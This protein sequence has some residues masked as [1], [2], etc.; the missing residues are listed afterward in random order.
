M[1]NVKK[2]V[3]ENSAAYAEF[4]YI[5]G[6]KFMREIESPLACSYFRNAY[7]N[8]MKT[9][10]VDESAPKY[11]N[12]LDGLEEAASNAGRYLDVVEYRKRH[13]AVTKKC[14]GK[15]A[16]ELIFSMRLLALAYKDV[17]NDDE[18]R[19]MR[20]LVFLKCKSLYGEAD[21][22]TIGAWGEYCLSLMVFPSASKML[23][24]QQSGMLRV[25]KQLMSQYEESSERKDEK[26]FYQ[27]SCAVDT[28]KDYLSTENYKEEIRDIDRSLLKFAREVYPPQSDE[29]YSYIKNLAY[30]AED[31]ESTR[32]IEEILDYRKK[33]AESKEDLIEALEEFASFHGIMSREEEA[34]KTEDEIRAMREKDLC[35][36]RQRLADANGNEPVSALVDEADLLDK[37]GRYD[38]ELACWRKIISLMGEEITEEYLE[39][40]E[41]EAHLLS[42]LHNEESISVW[43]EMW[44]ICC[45]NKKF[46]KRLFSIMKSLIWE[47]R[48]FDKLEGAL[49]AA[50]EGWDELW[51]EAT[52]LEAIGLRERIANCLSDLHRY[53]DEMTEYNTIASMYREY[54]G[55]T[56]ESTVEFM[57]CEAHAAEKAGKVKYAIELRK[58]VYQIYRDNHGEINPSTVF[59]YHR[60]VRSLCLAGKVKDALKYQREMVDKLTAYHPLMKS[61]NVIDINDDAQAMLDACLL[62]FHTKK[63]LSSREKAIREKTLDAIKD[64]DI[65]EITPLKQE[66]LVGLWEEAHGEKQDNPQHIPWETE[67]G[68]SRSGFWARVETDMVLLYY[69]D[70]YNDYIFNAEAGWK[71]YGFQAKLGWDGEYDKISEDAAIGLIWNFEYNIGKFFSPRPWEAEKQEK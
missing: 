34:D 7:E 71:K 50:Q 30:S 46:R 1:K 70:E 45:K 48:K 69:A 42:F 36:L 4:R 29:L 17:K 23:A 68:N 54:H 44:D 58:Q 2:S 11:L 59:S 56:S 3:G 13:L 25:A 6:V 27:M 61:Q 65:S 18:E 39:A 66:L 40:K 67:M 26:A 35:E 19:K 43:K 32:M 37:L 8:M 15:N 52:P 16:P 53:E 20:E 41:R 57:A 33:H 63:S 12:I 22:R 14:Y 60:W 31:E 21:L 49:L 9:V 51:V 24:E 28:L 62:L 47:Y 5:C 38:E 64:E 55:E 10:P